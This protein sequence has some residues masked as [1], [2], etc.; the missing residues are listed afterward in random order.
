MKQCK[1]KTSK[2]YSMLRTQSIS[3]PI[4][5]RSIMRTM[6]RDGL[7][8]TEEKQIRT[9]WDNVLCQSMLRRGGSTRVNSSQMRVQRS[10][11]EANSR[12][13]RPHWYQK[14]ADL[15]ITSSTL[16]RKK[17]QKRRET[18]QWK[19]RHRKDSLKCMRKN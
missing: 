2:K 6:A 19:H 4:R 15:P 17:N 3:R 1:S 10:S 13:R 11:S 18:K 12:T 5:S 16:M 9:S 14:S 7:R 8:T